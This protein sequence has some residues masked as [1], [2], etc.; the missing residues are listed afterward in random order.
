MK[1]VTNH[2]A[3]SPLRLGRSPPTGGCERA[4]QEPGL[5]PHAHVPKP[6]RVIFSNWSGDSCGGISPSAGAVQA[7]PRA[8]RFTSSV[9]GPGENVQ[10][11]QRENNHVGSDGRVEERR[12]LIFQR[13]H[14]TPQL[15][16]RPQEG[17][18]GRNEKWVFMQTPA[19]FFLLLFIS[20]TNIHDCTRTTH[21]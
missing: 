6:A 4:E 1:P 11:E 19:V 7:A 12:A 14:Q 3:P 18:R 5:L 2:N 16:P 13:K 8:A 15:H 10:G 17:T 21:R 20:F 9:P